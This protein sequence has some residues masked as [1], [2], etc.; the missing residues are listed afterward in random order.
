MSSPTNY[1]LIEIVKSSNPSKKYSAILLNKNTGR[2]KVVNFGARGYEHYKDSTPVKAYSSKDH[3]D[4]ERR[5][6]YMLRHHNTESKTVALRETP[7]YS[8]KWFS[9]KYLW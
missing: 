4:P 9:T 1:K 6:R 2:E 5:R 7:K 3:L 8:A